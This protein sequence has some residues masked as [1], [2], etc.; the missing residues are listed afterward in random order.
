MIKQDD[1]MRSSTLYALNLLGIAASSGPAYASW[2]H[3]M[4]RTMDARIENTAVSVLNMPGHLA[5]GSMTFI[6]LQIRLLR[7]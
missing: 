7:K 3:F 2:E 5:L 1:D 6:L 4:P